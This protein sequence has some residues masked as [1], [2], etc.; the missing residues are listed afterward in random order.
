LLACRLRAAS[1][2]AGRQCE[3]EA[4]EKTA[5]GCHVRLPCRALGAPASDDTTSRMLPNCYRVIRCWRHRR[6]A[7]RALEHAGEALILA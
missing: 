3:R 2:L 7:H 1:Q 5:C 6:I 4:G